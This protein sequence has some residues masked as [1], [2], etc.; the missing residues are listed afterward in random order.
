[1]QF[2]QRACTNIEFAIVLADR[3]SAQTFC[4][5]RVNLTTKQWHCPSNLICPAH[6]AAIGR[7]RF[8][9]PLSLA[10]RAHAA[11]Y[12]HQDTYHFYRCILLSMKVLYCECNTHRRSLLCLKLLLLVV[13]L[14]DYL[15]YM[16]LYYLVNV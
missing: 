6:T 2:A 12:K 5:H 1:M 11:H 14:A 9:L 13:R 10:L 4:W 15:A 8:A 16:M 7:V 3:D